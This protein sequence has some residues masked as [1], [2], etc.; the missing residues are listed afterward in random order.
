[1][2]ADHLGERRI[3]LTSLF[4]TTVGVSFLALSPTFHVFALGCLVF[5]LGSGMY[6]TP[7]FSILAK[8]FPDQTAKLHGI[9]YAMGGVDT[10]LPILAGIIAA[11]T[12]WRAGFGFVLSGLLIALAGLWYV[13]PAPV[14]PEEGADN[15]LLDQVQSTVSVTTTSKLFVPFLAVVA[16][17]IVYQ[18]LTAFFP[19]YLIDSK[20]IASS[21]VMVIYGLFFLLGTGS[22]IYGGVLGDRYDLESLLFGMASLAG[23]GLLVIALEDSIVLISVMIVPLSFISGFISLANTHL[24]SLLPTEAQGGGLG[25]L[26]AG[27]LLAGAMSPTAV[28]YLADVN[29]FTES[30]LGLA[31]VLFLGAGLCLLMQY[32][33]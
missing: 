18:S 33:F 9:A 2:L 12:T 28:G 29:Y 4:V 25:V 16:I 13:V 10:V 1:M 26:R 23:I 3:L 22:Q 17:A 27:I 8:R 24:I 14:G 19:L 20:E 30:M 5:G 32:R 31:G 21:H 11:A 6:S 15:D 7:Q